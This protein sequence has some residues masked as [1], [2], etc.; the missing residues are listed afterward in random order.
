[1]VLRVLSLPFFNIY[2]I[3][4]VVVALIQ[5]IIFPLFCIAIESNLQNF[6]MY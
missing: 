2:L 3:K 1:M 6:K 5:R 4:S